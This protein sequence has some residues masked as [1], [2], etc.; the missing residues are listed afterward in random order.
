M[1]EAYLI[2]GWIE[3]QMRALDY[4][5]RDL[6]A[7]RLAMLEAI[8]NAIRHGHHDDPHKAVRVNCLVRPYEVII[9]VHDQGLGFNPA[10]VPDCRLDENI[11]RPGGRGLLL[12][13]AYTTELHFNLA[14]NQ[15]TLYR[16]RTTG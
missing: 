4:P 12:M 9:E 16:R 11:E 7:V 5:P 1:A 3:D 10:T 15:V 13:R 6:F 14:G 2:A 8:S